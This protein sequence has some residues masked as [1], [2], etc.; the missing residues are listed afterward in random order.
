MSVRNTNQSLNTDTNHP[1]GGKM[2]K[3]ELVGIVASRI[4]LNKKE[5]KQV[6]DV[7]LNSIIKG[8]SKDKRL[9][10]RGLGTFEVRDRAPREGRII[11]TG[12]KVPIPARKMPVFIPGKILKR[13]V[14]QSI[15]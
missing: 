13:I 7:I 10:I 5:A 1:K 9:E 11:S 3:D 2:N 4:N 6:L 15:S 12:E 14:N 8:L